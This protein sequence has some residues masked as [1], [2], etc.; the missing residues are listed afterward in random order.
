MRLRDR[1][2]QPIISRGL[3]A[4]GGIA[5]A[6]VRIRLRVG[7][8]IS[9]EGGI[10][11]DGAPWIVGKRGVD[12][13]AKSVK[14]PLVVPARYTPSR[15]RSIGYSP[16]CICLR[17]GSVHI[18]CPTTG[19]V[20]EQ[21]VVPIHTTACSSTTPVVGHIQC[22]TTGVVDEQA[23]VCMGLAVERIQIV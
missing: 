15:N 14:S 21:A 23:V 19:V 17:G 10:S 18:Q 22:P 12:C 1:P 2:I 13:M 16:V 6:S 8:I 4:I 3:K 9:V 7:P 11:L 5:R 20:D